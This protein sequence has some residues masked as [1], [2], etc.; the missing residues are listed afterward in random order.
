[1]VIVAV[2]A[3]ITIPSLTSAASD[4]LL[5]DLDALGSDAWTVQ[6]AAQG[7][8]VRLLPDGALARASDLP[9]A[10]EVL[11]QVDS[12]LSLRLN[13]ED[14][15]TYPVGV[16][17][18]SGTP[19]AGALQTTEGVYR[20][21]PDLLFGVIGSDAAHSLD[22][23]EFPTTLLV[24]GHPVVVTGVLTGDPLLPELATSVVLP[25]EDVLELDPSVTSDKIVVRGLGLP[26]A[27]DIGRGID[28]LQLVP[29]RVEQPDALVAA[30]QQSSGTLET[31]GIAATL[32]AFGIAALGIA[33]MLTSS[34][35]QRTAEL[36][37]RRVH[38][39][40]VRAIAALIAAEGLMIG[41]TGGLLGSLLS[42]S[43]VE[44]VTSMRGWPY[45]FDLA[46]YLLAGGTAILLCLVASVPPAIVAVRVQP[47][48]AFAVE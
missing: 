10:S 27:A 15:R 46:P 47:A 4:K 13:N 38:G 22:I 18:L 8:E 39:A 37:V 29:L 32:A 2:L 40:P 14:T 48:R 24:G 19:G 41:L 1:M 30:R 3:M 20:P 43:V 11:R 34:V 17:G 25:A 36:A 44:T 6:P 23:T 26:N 21:V 42:I 9:G 45:T 28:P 12:S 5:A 33:I 7:G 35:R 31:L 16:V